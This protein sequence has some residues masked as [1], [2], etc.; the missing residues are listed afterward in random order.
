MAGNSNMSA[1]RFDVAGS[2][3]SGRVT[4]VLTRLMSAHG[5]SAYLRSDSG[6]EFVSETILQ[7]LT[8]ACIETAIIDPVVGAI[9]PET[10]GPKNQLRSNGRCC[11][12]L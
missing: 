2:I 1:W 8:D 11:R 10:S 3:R 4:N 12:F 9:F 6:P 5:T 7:W